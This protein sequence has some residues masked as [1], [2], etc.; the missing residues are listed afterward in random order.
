VVVAE[1]LML[2]RQPTAFE[3][4]I[5]LIDPS[6]HEA[7]ADMLTNARLHYLRTRHRMTPEQRGF[8]QRFEWQARAELY[9]RIA[10]HEPIID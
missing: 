8:V 9:R 6:G 1:P 5:H 2:R 7:A 10:A 4:P 3:R